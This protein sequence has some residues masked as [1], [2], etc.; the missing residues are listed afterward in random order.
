MFTKIDGI[1][2]F[3]SHVGPQYPTKKQLYLS[4]QTIWFPNALSGLIETIHDVIISSVLLRGPHVIVRAAQVITVE[5][6]M[7]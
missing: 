1:R 6:A 4:D 5:T 2:A 3:L 7:D